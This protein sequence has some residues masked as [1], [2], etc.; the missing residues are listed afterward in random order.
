M[1]DKQKPSLL[2]MFWR[3]KEQFVK[4]RSNPIIATP[5]IIVTVIYIMASMVK[6]LL[7]RAEDLMLPGMTVHSR[8]GCSNCESIYCNVRVY[9]AGI[10]NFVYDLDLFSHF[11]NR[12]KKYNV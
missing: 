1:N 12:K 7:I 5:L 3:P 8:Y 4:I 9:I 2:K 6:A 10:Y 11:E